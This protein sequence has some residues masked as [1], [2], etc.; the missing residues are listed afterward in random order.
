M[1]TFIVFEQKILYHSNY[2][3]FNRKDFNK[4]DDVNIYLAFLGFWLFKFDSENLS[5]EV[6][7]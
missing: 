2:L 4:F 5:Y 1:C 3:K 7:N 6:F